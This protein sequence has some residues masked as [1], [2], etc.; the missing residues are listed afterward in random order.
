MHR[1]LAL[2]LACVAAFA[3]AIFYVAVPMQ[4]PTARERQR[5]AELDSRVRELEQQLADINAATV[6]ALERKPVAAPVRRVEPE[7]KPAQ[8]P[9]GGAPGGPHKVAQRPPADWGEDPATHMLRRLI[10]RGLARGIDATDR[11]VRSASG[12]SEKRGAMRAMSVLS[13]VDDPAVDEALRRYTHAESGLLRVHAAM[14]L[15]RRGDPE[16]IGGVVD[17]LTEQLATGDVLTKMKTLG[18]LRLAG[19]P[20]S[21]TQILPE[22]DNSNSMVRRGAIAL[23]GGF[24]DEAVHA[25]LTALL[26]DP[27]PGVQRAAEQALA[28]K[29]TP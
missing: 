15:K 22:L 18:L 10:E 6:D 1:D 28:G 4:L 17:E 12:L 13:E 16:P 5:M 29:K 21:A 20:R 14:I 8:P 24:D 11:L 7:P 19:G 2:S 26:S 25:A 27:D 9:V 3:L 23:L